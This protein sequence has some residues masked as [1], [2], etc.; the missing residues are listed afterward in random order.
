MRERMSPKAKNSNTS[1]KS[2]VLPTG[3][4]AVSGQ[5]T[6]EEANKIFGL[7]AEKKTKMPNELTEAHYVWTKSSNH[8][9]NAQKKYAFVMHVNTVIQYIV[10][11]F[12]L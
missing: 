5:R 9:D 1:E 4:L 10:K 12:L 2:S 7:I 8:P 6:E 11:V 3:G